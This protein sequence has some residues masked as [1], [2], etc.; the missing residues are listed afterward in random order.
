M[1]NIEIKV[2]KTNPKEMTGFIWGPLEKNTFIFN[3]CDS[4]L[5][6]LFAWQDASFPSVFVNVFP[7]YPSV[8]TNRM[9]NSR[10]FSRGFISKKI[11]T[12]TASFHRACRY[13]K[14]DFKLGCGVLL[15]SKAS[16]SFLKKK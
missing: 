8:T 4:W 14:V 11:F 15:S 2:M 13:N 3:I 1:K 5:S 10:C 6:F 16:Q 12:R 7:E 9:E